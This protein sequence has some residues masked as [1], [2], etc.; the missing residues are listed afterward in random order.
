MTRTVF[1]FAALLAACAT[2]PAAEQTDWYA[3]RVDQP[4]AFAIQQADLEI[5]DAEWRG[6][7]ACAGGDDGWREE[8]VWMRLAAGAPDRETHDADK[9]GLD[10]SLRALDAAIALY[11]RGGTPADGPA[12]RP[13]LHTFRD[14]LAGADD[15]RVRALFTRVIGDQG[16]R[17]ALNARNVEDWTTGLSE[18]A[19]GAW[20]EAVL[21][22][23]NR[24][25]CDNTAW[26]QH[27][28][29]D[30]RWFDI[31]TYGAEADN[32]AWL[33]AQ[34][35]DY[36]PAF[37]NAVLTRLRS[38]PEGHTSPRRIAY[39]SDRVSVALGQPQRYGTQMECLDGAFVPRV[40]LEDEADIDARRAAA[41]LEPLAE[42]SAA[43]ASIYGC[44]AE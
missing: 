23:M 16:Y 25:D 2:P 15:P 26:L 18:R 38:L 13:E 3:M 10:A 33:I 30:I 39:L 27:Q 9:A 8:T 21:V 43:M 31:P 42:Y 37:Q 36:S 1:A 17:H 35:A 20:R 34:H 19:P 44:A 14:A 11:L 32:A 22:R 12:L 7:G 28:L 40:G 6:A 29:E 24:I 4:A 41:G 5:R